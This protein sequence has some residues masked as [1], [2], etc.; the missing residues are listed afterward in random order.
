ML[1]LE[2]LGSEVEVKSADV[3]NYEQMQVAVTEALEKFGQ[4]NGVIHAAGI[5]GGGI[6]QLK[7][8]NIANSVLAPK[9]KGTLVLEKILNL[10]NINLDF[11]VLCSSHSSI[12]SEFGQIDYCAANAF[13]DIYAHDRTYN[14][15]Q[16]TAINW[17]LGKR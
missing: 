3:A 13:L 8:E 11:L 14:S 1:A 9:I 12:L 17:E 15:D 4:I 2:E 7:T 6:I 16:F 10:K 5:A